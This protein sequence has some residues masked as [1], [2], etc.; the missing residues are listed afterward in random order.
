MRKTILF[1]IFTLCLAMNAVGQDPL[2][3]DAIDTARIIKKVSENEAAFRQALTTYV[4]NRDV[5]VSILGLGGQVAGQYTRNSL[6]TLTPDGT[7]LEK[8]IY[9]PVATVPPGFITAEDLEDLGGVNPFAIEPSAVPLY[10]FTYIGTEK[11]DELN[12]YVFE[13]TPKLIPDPKKSKQRLFTGRIWID[14]DDLLIVKS[15]GKGVPETKKNKFPVVES[16]RQNVDGKWWFPWDTRSDDELVFDDGSVVR[17]RIRVKY[18][19]YRVGRSEVRILDDEEV[20]PSPTPT[21]TP[22]PEL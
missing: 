1:S 17:L 10:N 5:S 4:F 15:K 13:V 20:V 7:R 2:R 8:I 14:V 6:M 16:T 18:N 22:K 9:A 3:R 21:P 11:I 12:L 19:N